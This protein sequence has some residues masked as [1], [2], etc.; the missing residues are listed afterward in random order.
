MIVTCDLAYDGYSSAL[1]DFY[2]N[3]MDIF[4]EVAQKAFSYDIYGHKDTESEYNF[5]NNFHYLLGALTF[6]FYERLN[7]YNKG[8][9]GTIKYYYDKYNLD[10]YR[11]MFLCHGYN[12]VPLFDAFLVNPF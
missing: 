3:G 4:G 9:L 7:D 8:D 1:K 12:I 10:C 2:T 5:M 11:K 6:M